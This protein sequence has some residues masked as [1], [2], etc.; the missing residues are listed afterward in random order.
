MKRPEKKAKFPYGDNDGTSYANAQNNLIY[1]GYN[2]AC[3]DWEKYIDYCTNFTNE[4][5]LPSVEEMQ[6]II[7]SN[8]KVVGRG[9]ESYFTPDI[10]KIAEA[11]HKRLGG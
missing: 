10:N 4:K 3:D 1:Q 6:V 8:C 5:S 2:Q 11:I 9:T 7:S